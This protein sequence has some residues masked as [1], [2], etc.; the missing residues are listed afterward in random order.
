MARSSRPL[1]ALAYLARPHVPGRPVLVLHSWWGLTPSFID[2]ADR[3]ARRGLVVG[4]VDL[5]D[6]AVARTA[7]ES[8]ALRSAQAVRVQL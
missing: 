6:G 5:Y 1:P 2:F 8:K 3:L 7:E 4:C